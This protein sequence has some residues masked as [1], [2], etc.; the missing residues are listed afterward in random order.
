[1]KKVPKLT[2]KI[3]IPEKV[4][5]QLN[6]TIVKAKGPKGET[7]QVIFHPKVSIKKEGNE[8]VLEMES[9]DSYEKAILYS[10]KAH[11]KN[12]FIGVLSGYVYN[13]K[14]CSGHFPITVKADKE[15]VVVSN[16]LGEKIPRKAKILQH[17]NVKV[18]GDQII[19]EGTNLND[20]SQTAANIEI[21]TRILH[22]DRR[23]FQ[24]GIFITSK[25]GVAL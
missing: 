12:L 3:K 25:A 8:L 5:I 14:V 9:P 1:M 2:E 4:E 20:V 16:F 13:L 18:Q 24:D 11:L 10:L 15:T 21:A 17:V 6:G 7:E 22:R 19:V 23:R